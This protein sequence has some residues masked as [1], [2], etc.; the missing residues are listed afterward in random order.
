MG[1][2]LASMTAFLDAERADRDRLSDAT[3]SRSWS[4]LAACSG[5]AIALGL[6]LAYSSQRRLVRLCRSFEAAIEVL[7]AKSDRQ[8][9]EN[10]SLLSE[11]MKYYAIFTLDADGLITSWNGNAERIL[12]YRDDD[13]M[14]RRPSHFY[15]DE[16]VRRDV[17]F[18][19]MEWASV[20][21]RVEDERWLTRKDGFR[22]KAHVAMMSI[23]DAN[24]ILC[25]YTN[26][27][28]EVAD[29]PL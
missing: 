6:I 2:I 11:A 23:R 13:V 16:D 1:E 5:S 8:E 19:D 18:R 27:I 22:F 4:V 3:Q 21:G 12:G 24:G 17:F 7:E 10:L 26:V 29:Q 20:E 9:R 14:A 28:H 15:S 25:G